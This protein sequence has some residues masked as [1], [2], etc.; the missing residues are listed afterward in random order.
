MRASFP[1]RALIEQ[2]FPFLV[3]LPELKRWA[4]LRSDL[5][6]GLTVAMLLIPQSMA[7]A[8]L[9]GLPVYMGL[10]AAFI[11]IIVAALFGSSRYLSTGPVPVTSLLTA[12][13]MMSI[14][15]S[16]TAEYIQ[17]AILLTLIAGVIQLLLGLLRFGVVVNFL[18]YPVMLGFINAV[19]LI[20]ASMQ[21]SALLGVSAVTE[22][23]YYQTVIQVFQDAI[24]APHWSTLAMASVAFLIMLGGRWLWPR[25]PHILIAVAVTSVLSW[26]FGYEKVE[27]ISVKQIMS[28]P[29]QEML[30]NYESFPQEMSLLREGVKRAETNARLVLKNSPEDAELI[31]EAVNKVNQAK[32]QMERRV[33]HHN[34]D[35]G[36]LSRL[37][38]SREVTLEGKVIFLVNQQES[39]ETW[40]IAN[41]IPSKQEL[42]VHGGGEIVGHIPQGLPQIKAITWSWDAV[43]RLLI[44][45]LVI[46][47]VGFTEAITIAKHIATTS[48]QRLKINQ[49]LLAQ[50]LAKCVGSFFQ[51]MPVSGSFTRTTI[52]YKAGAKT[53]FSSIVA[54]LIVMMTLL[55][56]TP[57]F[58]HL[59]YATLAAVI[60]VG[61]L[62]LLDLKELRRIWQV[63]RHEGFVSLLTFILTLILAPR[64]AHALILG[65]L[66]SLGVYL[67][68][69]MRPRFSEHIR[70]PDGDWVET[71]D[72]KKNEQVTLVRF[73]GSLYFANASYFEEN[74]L[75]LITTRKKLRYIILDCVGINKLDASGLKTLDDLSVQLKDVGIQLWFTRVR[76]QVMAV[77]KQGEIYKEFGG[78]Y[79]YKNNEAAW[80]A[81]TQH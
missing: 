80:V 6:A 44:A 60:M 74:M 28:A 45:A 59:P 39:A 18:S 21:L 72:V 65:M 70:N 54:G 33:V 26:Y 49:E 46:A 22:P 34:N 31:D 35:A 62:G 63:S 9:A 12:V 64:I 19:A 76:P 24:A 50:G 29:T 52:N 40:R 17:Y 42:T 7:Y 2:L 23:H 5:L 73:G 57:L 55:W 4:T 61:V 66:M 20:I 25:L 3:W 15:A 37:R 79:F 78:Q 69:T 56:L 58:Y 36:E 13:A 11:P 77:L 75:Q 1:G 10:Y 51:S 53:G 14:A 30:A 8:H 38:L 71:T 16:G 47:L 48:R 68:E 27:T 81:L 43:T 67:Y 32:W 41:F